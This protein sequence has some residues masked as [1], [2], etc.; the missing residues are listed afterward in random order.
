[1]RQFIELN[2]RFD[3]YSQEVLSLIYRKS[4]VLL[5]ESGVLLVAKK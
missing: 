3:K 1:M 2:V 5:T 4:I